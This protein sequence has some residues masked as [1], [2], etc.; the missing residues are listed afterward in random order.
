MAGR[1]KPLNPGSSGLAVFGS[2]LRMYRESGGYKLVEFGSMINNSAGTISDTEHGKSRCDRSLAESADRELQT[3]GAL[4][5]LWDLLVK[6]A[7]YPRWFD[8]PMYEARAT[9]LRTF[10]L[11]AIYGLLQTDDYARA[12]LHGD[13]AAVEA[14]MNRQAILTRQEPPPPF[15]ICVMNE[16]A[17]WYQVGTPKVM[18]DQLM[19]LVASASDRIC[20]QVVPNGADRPEVTGAFVL[21]TLE[22]R[23]EVSYI[24]TA[25]R[26]ISTG[27]KQ[28]LT[29][30]SES[31]DRIRAQALPAQMPLERSLER[32]M[33]DGPE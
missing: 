4:A 14:R 27:D 12:L 25:A 31:F 6:G 8:W 1:P 23:S 32:R 17:L 33:N 11:L 3:G 15:I 19:H 18:H 5:H 26:G 7:V 22:D 13:E 29:T 20:I 21:A 28:D 30:L 16:A 2:M 9:T 24:E 10:Q